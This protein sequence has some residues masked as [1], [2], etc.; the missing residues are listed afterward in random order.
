MEFD[1]KT[2]PSLASLRAFELT[3][4]TGNFAT[5]AR[6]LNV[7]HAAIAQRVRSLETD[8][9]VSLVRRSGRN[10]VLTHA[11]ARLATQ[12]TDGFRTI[13]SGI[14]D[15]RREESQRPVRITTTVFF[16]QIVLLPKL[17]DFWRR[18]T[19]T[20]VSVLPT[21]DLV[22]ISSLGIDLAIR[23]SSAKPDWPGL[24]LEPLI[25]SELIVVGAPS[26][27]TA[28]MPPLEELPWIWTAG[29]KYE[30]EALNAFGLDFRKLKNADIGVQTHQYALAR[31]GMGLTTA[32]EVL[33]REDLAS[34]ALR[35]VPVP[36]PTSITFYVVTP[37]RQVRPQA[38]EFIA[39]LKETLAMEEEMCA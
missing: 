34:G 12:L 23:A 21:H 4:R 32:P 6:E 7:T 38:Q 30:E 35:R 16:S 27:V 33:V 10:V 14:E 9:G 24:F 18:H 5:A 19:G 2:L 37:D 1:W 22:D 25:A 39:W 20:L 13:A 15:L 29:A 3:A 8:L 31:Q 26:L 17:E 28:D 11:G 36:S